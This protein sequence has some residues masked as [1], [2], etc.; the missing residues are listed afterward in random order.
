MPK[1]SGPLSS[2]WGGENLRLLTPEERQGNMVLSDDAFTQTGRPILD[3]GRG[4]IHRQTAAEIFDVPPE[5]VTS[6]QRVAARAINFGHTN[7]EGMTHKAL[8]TESQIAGFRAMYG[9]GYSDMSAV[10]AMY[11]AYKRFIETADDPDPIVQIE[12]G[13]LARH[14][15]WE[16]TQRQRI[17]MPS[18]VVLAS[19]AGFEGVV[20]AIQS[21]SPQER[22]GS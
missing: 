10:K 18:L 3:T 17:Q 20:W 19:L 16:E 14:W 21:P 9:G 7:R 12:R 22:E 5:Q 13:L 6:S 2:A 8:R 1:N 15:V 11:E 4:D